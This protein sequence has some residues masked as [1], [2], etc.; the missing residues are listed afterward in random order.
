MRCRTDEDRLRK[1]CQSKDSLKFYLRAFERLKSNNWAGMFRYPYE[2]QLLLDAIKELGYDGYFNFEI[3]GEYYSERRSLPGFRFVEADIGSPAAAAFS[4]SCLLKKAE[5]SGELLRALPVF[6]KARLAELKYIDRRTPGLIKAG[7]K[8]PV[9]YFERE[10]RCLSGKELKAAAEA[11]SAEGNIAVQEELDRLLA[12]RLER[13]FG[14]ERRI[15]ENSSLLKD[16]VF[17]Y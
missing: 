3:N 11:A 10:T 8:D 15:L 1:F 5:Y 2:R 17:S 4:K 6:K 16:K 13:R 12:A 14:E 7:E 9:G